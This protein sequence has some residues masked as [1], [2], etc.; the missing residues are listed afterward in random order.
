[1]MLSIFKDDVYN[2]NDNYNNNNKAKAR[3]TSEDHKV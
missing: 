1:M 3:P 2:F